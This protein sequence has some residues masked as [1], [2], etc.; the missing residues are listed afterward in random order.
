MDTTK[1]KDDLTKALTDVIADQNVLQ[2][3][4]DALDTTFPKPASDPTW[5]AV[6]LVLTNAGWQAPAAAAEPPVDAPPAEG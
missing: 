5:D 4:L 6:K 3:A 1:L 2:S